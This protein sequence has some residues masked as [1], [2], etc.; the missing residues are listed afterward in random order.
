MWSEGRVLRCQRRPCVVNLMLNV[1]GCE[2][3]TPF[4]QMTWK[5]VKH[6]F[7]FA[8]DVVVNDM[9]LPLDK[10]LINYSVFICDIR[11]LAWRLDLLMPCHP[12]HRPQTTPFHL[13]LSHILQLY[14]PVV[15]ISFSSSFLQVFFD[16]SFLYGLALAVF[17]RNA[18]YKS[19]FYLLT[20][21]WYPL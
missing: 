10:P 18:L 17:S 20:Y 9:R 13:V 11:W 15:H 2:W 12:G 16:R 14:K 3:A 1:A 21:L 7:W 6:Q 19:T 8:R 4:W 5:L